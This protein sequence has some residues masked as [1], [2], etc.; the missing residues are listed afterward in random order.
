M[1]VRTRDELISQFN[2][3]VGEED[4]RDEVL[5]FME[6]MRD[7]FNEN[8]AET[9][10][11]LKQQVSDIDSSWRKKYRDAFLGHKEEIPDE[12]EPDEPK[13]FDDLFTFN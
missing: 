8:G 13:S 1:A 4:T 3:I 2:S 10:A 7:T 9:I 6:D 11:N 12:D 5:S